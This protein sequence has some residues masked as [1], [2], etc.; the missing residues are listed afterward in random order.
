MRW[1]DTEHLLAGIFDLLAAGNW[2]R[3]HG[4]GHRP[5][6]IRRPGD[7]AGQTR[8]GTVVPLSEARKR[9]ARSTGITQAS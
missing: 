6:P 3:Q 5:K 1:T 7:K 9:L 2:Q 8:Y 4:K